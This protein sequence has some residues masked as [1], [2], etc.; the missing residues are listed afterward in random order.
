MM[1]AGARQIDIPNRSKQRKI[2]YLLDHKKSQAF[3]MFLFG[4]TAQK[5]YN[6]R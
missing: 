5:S 6:G 2:P 4:P 3:T 1:I